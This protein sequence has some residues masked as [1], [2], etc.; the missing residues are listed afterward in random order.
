[1]Y[2]ALI[3]F[4]DLEDNNYRYHPG[5]IFPRYGIEVSAERISDLLTGN[6]RRHI[7]VIE[8]VADKPKRKRAKK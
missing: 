3:S 2:K 5:D 8:E 7:P 4:T 1:M 6:N